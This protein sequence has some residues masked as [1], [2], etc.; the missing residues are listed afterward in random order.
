MNLFDFF[1]TEDI[2]EGVRQFEQTSEAVLLDVRTAE[3][4]QEGHIP[5]SINISLHE[6]F[7]VA[8]II[9]NHNI[10]LYVYCQSGARS[11]QAV[12]SLKKMGY[13][14]VKNIGGIN[15][16]RGKVEK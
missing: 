15:Q 10:P 12:E 8:E 9:S 2:N 4:Y 5:K 7:E 13:T 11:G 16:Y 1:R 14:E 6:I 3:E